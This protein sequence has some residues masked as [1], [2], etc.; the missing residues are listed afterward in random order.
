VIGAESEA[1]GWECPA[2]LRRTWGPGGNGPS[3]CGVS[4]PWRT[5]WAGERGC[6]VYSA[7]SRSHLEYCVPA[8]QQGRRRRAGV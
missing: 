4:R 5:R 8:P 3:S 7:L 1:P 2:L 6:S